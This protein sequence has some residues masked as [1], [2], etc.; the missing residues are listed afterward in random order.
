[1]KSAG[2]ITFLSAATLLILQ[3]C[4]G[5]QLGPVKPARFEG[6]NTI[7]VPLFKNETLEPRAAP[8]LTNAV[9]ARMQLDG[10]YKVGDPKRGGD[11]TLNGT[12][13]NVERRQLRSARFDTLATRE[14]NYRVVCDW[15]LTTP[16][17]TVIDQGTDFG[18]A[19]IFLDPNFQL[20]ERQALPLAAEDFAEK[21]VSKISEG[22]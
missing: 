20:S 8:I 2:L 5:Y 9:I 15:T 6:I 3:G 19:A 16:D 21:V 12:F 11:A 14:L 10:T 1:M 4:A 22:W 18:E 13:K 17:G 7:S